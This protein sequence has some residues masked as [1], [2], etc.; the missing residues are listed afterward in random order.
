M[1]TQQRSKKQWAREKRE[2]G[3]TPEFMRH[4]EQYLEYG[5]RRLLKL[6]GI[7]DGFWQDVLGSAA[8]FAFE[9]K[10]G[11][12]FRACYDYYFS[13]IRFSKERYLT[14]FPSNNNLC[15]VLAHEGTH[16]LQF[17]RSLATHVTGFNQLGKTH[18]ILCPRDIV[19]LAALKE[20]QACAIEKLAARAISSS[21]D[22]KLEDLHL[23]TERHLAIE[24]FIRTEKTYTKWKHDI[25]KYNILY[26]ARSI[27]RLSDRC[28][29]NIVFVRLTPYDVFEMGQ[30][31][32]ALNFFTDDDG[33]VADVYRR[34]LPVD[35]S[36]QTQIDELHQMAGITDCETLPTIDDMLAIMGKTRMQYLLE[37]QNA[38][39][40]QL[41]IPLLQY[42]GTLQMDLPDYLDI[43]SEWAASFLSRIG[44]P[45]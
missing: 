1:L 39:R 30:A 23:R 8:F 24:N 31:F 17:S 13:C 14:P 42:D 29:R 43:H 19:W 3:I 45:A 40:S 32:P 20:V 26:I 27:K 10:K 2:L 41:G 5:Q 38:R 25:D 37:I 44:Q 7:F 21:E 35:P 33:E 6:G 22:L 12:P 36:I 16:A 9:E 11:A 28:N 4:W 18:F 34:P 15:Q